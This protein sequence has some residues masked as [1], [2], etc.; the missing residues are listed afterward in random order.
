MQTE[1]K[2]NRTA[3]KILGRKLQKFLW[4]AYVRV[5]EIL[6]NHLKS[7]INIEENLHNKLEVKQKKIINYVL[8]DIY[9]ERERLWEI[10]K[11]V[12]I[13]VREENLCDKILLTQ[14]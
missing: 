14:I 3:K 5:G 12:R 10:G 11:G 4:C 2:Q 6:H 8:F 1:I 7:L 9:M 13:R